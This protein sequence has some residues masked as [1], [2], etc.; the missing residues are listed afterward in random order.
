MFGEAQLH[1]EGALQS[2]R[3]RAIISKLVERPGDALP[4]R[5]ILAEVEA[6][7]EQ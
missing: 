4:E 5:Q 1:A 3:S 2:P 7:A 6:L